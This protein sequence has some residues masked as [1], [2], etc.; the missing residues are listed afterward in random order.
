[1]RFIIS[2]RRASCDGD[3][4]KTFS[5]RSAFTL[6]EL[7]VV[8]AVIAIIAAILL[9]VLNRAQESGRNITCLNNLRQLEICWHLYL[10]DNNDVLVPNNS[11]ALVSATTNVS[12]GSISTQISWLP[13]VDATEEVNPS[14]IING[15]LFPYNSQLGIYHCPSDTSTLETSD[16]D[17]LPQ[18]RWRSYNMS[19]SVNGYP[20]F[21]WELSDFIPM[22]DKLSEIRHPDPS[23]VFVFID[24]NSDGI[25]DAEFGNPPAASPYFEQDVWW[26]LPSSRHF[27]G[28]NLSFADGH[29][30]HWKW[31][32]PKVWTDY[33]QPVAPG[34]MPDYLRVQ[35]AMDQVLPI[36]NF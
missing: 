22:W 15:L 33:V 17:P 30:E 7:L 9:P 24:E 12:V 26:D 29:V 13:D 3:G 14:N 10:E 31:V 36:F 34:E 32:V 18:L 11:V 28:G 23:S 35:S 21:S 27:R 8:V 19:Q 20:T 2:T 1:M 6:I 5:A 25:L 16:G 4:G